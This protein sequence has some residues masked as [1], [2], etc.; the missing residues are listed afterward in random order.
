MS[1]LAIIS[2]ILVQIT[3]LLVAYKETGIHVSERNVILKSWIHLLVIIGN[4]CTTH[5]PHDL[6]R[7]YLAIIV[8]LS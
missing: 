5:L 3:T 7:L 6:R 4:L 8:P 2:D 1:E